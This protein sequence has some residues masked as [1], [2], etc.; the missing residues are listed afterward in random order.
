M[1]PNLRSNVFLG[2]GS[3]VYTSKNGLI[4]A[5]HHEFYGLLL[6][7]NELMG[8]HGILVELTGIFMGSC[9]SR[10][11]LLKKISKWAVRPGPSNETPSERCRAQ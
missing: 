3:K 1:T 6:G 4:S 11:L 8:F 9:G 2:N 10:K 7:F 5:T